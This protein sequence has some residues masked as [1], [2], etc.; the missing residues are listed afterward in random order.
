MIGTFGVRAQSVKGMPISFN[1]VAA[2]ILGG[3]GRSEGGLLELLD[4]LAV[5]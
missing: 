3:A 1:G 4:G 2:E 5:I